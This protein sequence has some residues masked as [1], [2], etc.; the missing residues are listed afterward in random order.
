M[1][2]LFV[3]CDD[4]LVLWLNEDGQPLEGQNPYGGGSDKY[5]L[6]QALIDAV[7]DFLDTNLDWELVVWS[8]GGSQYA[9]VWADRCFPFKTLYDED[10]RGVRGWLLSAHVRTKDIALPTADDTCVDDQVLG[11]AGSCLTWQAFV[12]AH[13]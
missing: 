8:G 10:A 9:K 5:E 13:A 4:T 1:P 3:D 11:V 6:N 2:R 12:E 7:V